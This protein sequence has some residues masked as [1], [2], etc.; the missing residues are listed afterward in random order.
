MGKG[1]LSVDVTKRPST[2]FLPSGLATSS[3]P[4]QNHKR[5]RLIHGVKRPI[6]PGD[7]TISDPVTAIES[8]EDADDDVSI[9]STRRYYH[10]TFDNDD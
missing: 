9:R 8:L 2:T 4:N 1:D 5:K 7:H 10:Q 6:L 3:T